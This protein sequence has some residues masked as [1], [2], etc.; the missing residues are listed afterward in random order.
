MDEIEKD[1]LL[2]L[3]A[4]A[5][6]RINAALR[7]NEWMGKDPANAV[8]TYANLRSLLGVAEGTALRDAGPEAHATMEALCGPHGYA[9][10]RAM[11]AR[12]NK[13]VC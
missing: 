9:V 5:K 13:D 3:V 11:V 8:D 4:S 10:W 6:V 1:T 7:L 12:K 2:S